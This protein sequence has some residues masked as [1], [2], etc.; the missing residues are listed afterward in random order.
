[1][2]DVTKDRLLTFSS[3]S[4]DEARLRVR[5]QRNGISERARRT[6]DR[7][8][9]RRYNQCLYIETNVR[10]GTAGTAG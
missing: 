2:R 3:C 10:A 7:H 1:M 8:K 6:L 5:A 9:T 4:I